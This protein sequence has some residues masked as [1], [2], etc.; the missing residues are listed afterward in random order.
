MILAALVAA[1]LGQSPAATGSIRACAAGPDGAV[2]PGASMTASDGVTPPIAA[3]AGHDGCFL[4][5]SLPAGEYRVDATVAGFQPAAVRLRVAAGD[6]RRVTLTLLVSPVRETLTVV[7]TRTSQPQSE[8]PTAVHVIEKDDLQRSSAP[9]L[10]VALARI[11]AFSLFRRSS[12]LASHPTTQG[13]SLRG[14]GASG[15][16]RSLVL[17]DGLPENDPF[18]NWVYWNKL[19][20]LQIERVEVTGSG[21]SSL[22]GSSA[23]AGA[24][25]V[26]TRRPSFG[27][28]L[29]VRAQGGSRGTAH[30]EA[31]AGRG[32]DRWRLTA[33]G[34]VFR[35]DGYFLTPASVRG[36][37][38][39][40]VRSHHAT[41]NWRIERI[42]PRALLYQ[43]GRLFTE[44]RGNG[45]PFQQNETREALL[46]GGARVGTSGGWLTLDGFGRAQRFASGFSAI[47][48]DRRTETPTLGQRVP[49]VDGGASAQWSRTWPAHVLTIGGDLR[50]IAATDE[51]DVFAAG[52]HTRDRRIEARQS[53][54]G[55]FAQHAWWMT[56]RLQITLGARVDGWRNFA[57]SRRERD[58]ASGAAT[59]TPYA[60]RSASAWTPRAAVVARLGGGLRARAAAYTGFRAPSLNELY[61]P[62]RV[63]N[64]N[65]EGNPALSSERLAGG[66]AGLAYARGPVSWQATAFWTRLRDPI[67]NVTIASTPALIT[68]QR[69]NLGRAR[70][71]GVEVDAA[72]RP[73]SRLRVGAAWL[74][75]SA[76][77]TEFAADR[78]LEGLRLPQVPRHRG[79]FQISGRAP[80]D[81]DLDV[82]VRAE[83]KRFD[84]DRN[85]LRLGAYGLV[86]VRLARAIRS[87]A[88]AFVSVENLFDRAYA[89]QAT[90]VAILGTPR[91]VLAG[92]TLRWA[93]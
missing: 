50:A 56:R 1:T 75:V 2:L 30:A 34:R 21:L 71:D 67:S 36:A 64:V 37:I 60:R 41:V 76:R 51:E 78:P 20:L 58:R 89:V 3:R 68:R 80:G 70:V 61:R 86:D 42:M 62:F 79:S 63:G 18:G 48:A 27:S 7:A 15:A 11:P 10:D 25:A 43:A 46:S 38:D 92:V 17:V 83:G 88:E 19:P 74:F 26:L 8:A 45:T 69:Q 4:F 14:I 91:T 82:D 13:V 55:A 32:T 53:L 54:G 31:F 29:D 84:D 87:R 73:H 9:G 23:M 35:T 52:V 81:L 12:S 24:I 40:A 57:A 49:S 5:E 44:E 22:Y 65:T 90:P 77:V 16:S 33:A 28:G 66:E 47:S 39:R 59:A 85:Q 93:R 72:W 6:V